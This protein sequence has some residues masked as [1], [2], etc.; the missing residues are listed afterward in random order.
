MNG[1]TIYLRMCGGVAQQDCVNTFGLN[2]MATAQP[3]IPF[4]Q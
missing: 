4:A 2:A 1:Y 3:H